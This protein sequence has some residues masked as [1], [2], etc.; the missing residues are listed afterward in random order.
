M[1]AWA[2]ARLCMPWCIYSYTIPNLKIL[3]ALVNDSRT[4]LIPLCNNDSYFFSKL[5]DLTS[6]YKNHCQMLAM[7]ENSWH[8][9]SVQLPL[10]MNNWSS[11]GHPGNIRPWGGFG[12]CKY[13][14]V[15]NNKK[16]TWENSGKSVQ[17]MIWHQRLKAQGLTTKS[18]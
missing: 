7:L 4:N 15:S 8:G 11:F 12:M 3:D 10:L 1:L 14:S 17:T 5:H 16:I 9:K 6:W 13:V 18:L 2:L